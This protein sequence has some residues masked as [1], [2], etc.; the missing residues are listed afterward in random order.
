[1]VPYGTS[2]IE[3]K[4]ACHLKDKLNIKKGRGGNKKI[5]LNHCMICKQKI[6][7]FLFL[8]EKKRRTFSLICPR[9]A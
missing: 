9:I 3:I 2:K 6:L 1:M 7:F 4:I 8:K 5:N